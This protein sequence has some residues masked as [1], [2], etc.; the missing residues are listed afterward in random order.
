MNRPTIPF[1]GVKVSRIFVTWVCVPLAKIIACAGRCRRKAHAWKALAENR[2]W[3]SLTA[4]RQVLGI[5]QHP[6]VFALLHDFELTLLSVLQKQPSG[7]DSS[8]L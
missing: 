4:H 3:L 6:V 1:G 2:A 8:V 7:V 5:I